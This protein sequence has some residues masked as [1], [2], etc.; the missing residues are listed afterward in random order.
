MFSISNDT[1]PKQ[2][3]STLLTFSS[4][5]YK[6]DHYFLVMP[7]DKSVRIVRIVTDI[8]LSKNTNYYV[9]KSKVGTEY[10]VLTQEKKSII[11]I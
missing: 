10:L 2:F 5:E 1:L 3:D 4:F 6:K 11:K 7:L 9:E 8:I